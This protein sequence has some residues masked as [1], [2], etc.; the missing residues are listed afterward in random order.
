MTSWRDDPRSELV[1]EIEATIASL[2]DVEEA[3]YRVLES[4]PE[5]FVLLARGV[6]LALTAAASALGECRLQVPYAPMQPVNDNQGF[7]WCCTH[8]P[9]HCSAP[10]R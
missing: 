10:Q 4:Q 2:E 6:R 1:R 5:S 3:P 7:R 9:P 8:S